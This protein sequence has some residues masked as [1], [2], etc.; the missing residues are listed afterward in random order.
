MMG[1]M[2]FCLAGGSAEFYLALNK[3]I[4]F[5]RWEKGLKRE[6]RGRRS[7]IFPH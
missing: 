6:E 4:D 1:I 3:E 7:K 5:G 2:S